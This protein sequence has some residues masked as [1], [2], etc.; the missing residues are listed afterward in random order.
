[1]KKKLSPILLQ[2]VIT[3]ILLL[4]TTPIKAEEGISGKIIETMHVAGYTYLH[5]DT[6]LGM[7]WV[8]IPETEVKQGTSVKCKEG[9]VMKDFVSKSLNRSFETIIFS[10]GLMENSAPLHK[11]IIDEQT[12]DSFA[13]AVQ[14]E[15][16]TPTK[17]V[18]L[19]TMEG[20]SGGS[21]GAVVPYTEINIEK[22]A[23]KNGYT[24]DEIYTKAKELTGSIIQ[25]RGKV[26]KFSPMIMGKNWIHIQDGTGD[27]MQNSHDLVITSS[28]TVEEGDIVTLEGLLATEKDFGAGYSY[29]AIVE[30]ATIVK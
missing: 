25:V 6:A 13:A 3:A 27:P 28:E 7:Q 30:Q 22:A 2:L 10:P 19:Q 23:T 24:V 17:A 21:I 16:Q 8:A 26:M 9:V 11:E 14:A 1:M 15:Q 18:T 29:T 4:S 20:G 12:R 5:L